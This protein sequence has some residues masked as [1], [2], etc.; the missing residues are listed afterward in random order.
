[1]EERRGVYKDLV[2]QPEG[3]RLLGRPTR[4]WEDNLK[5]DFY[6]VG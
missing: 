6:E 3:K 4:S 1:M 2:L 5:K